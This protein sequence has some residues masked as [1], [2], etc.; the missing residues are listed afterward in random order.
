MMPALLRGG[1]CEVD[2][3]CPGLLPV[4]LSSGLPVSFRANAT[5]N[6]VPIGPPVGIAELSGPAAVASACASRVFCDIRL[7]RLERLV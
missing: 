7:S 6:P 2:V 1:L 5:P 4:V 3:L